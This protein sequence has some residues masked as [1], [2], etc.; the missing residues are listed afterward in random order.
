MALSAI[1]AFAPTTASAARTC[2]D[3]FR[4]EKFIS[5]SI[6]VSPEGRLDIRVTNSKSAMGQ[7]VNSLTRIIYRPLLLNRIEKVGERL[8]ADKRDNVPF[9]QK[10]SD[11]FGLEIRIDP[12]AL[13]NIPTSGPVI[14]VSNHPMNGVEGIALAAM[15]SK[16]RPDIK[17]VLTPLLGFVP[18]MAKN[19]IFANPYGGESARQANVQ[20]RQ[21]MVDELKAGHAFIIF[22][23]G[24]VSGK[25]GWLSKEV[26]DGQWKKGVAEMLN[27]VRDARVLP[28]FVEGTPSK[29]Y[30]NATLLADKVLKPFRSIR[31]GVG[32]VFHIREIGSRTETPVGLVIGQPIEGSEVLSWGNPARMMENLKRVT[33]NLRASRSEL[34]PLNGVELPGKKTRVLEPIAAQ[35]DMAVVHSELRN[36]ARIIYDRAPESSEKGMKVYLALGRDLPETMKEIGRL[37]EITFREVGEGS[38]KSRDLDSYDQDYYQLIAVD[39][40]TGAIA[41]GYRIAKVDEILKTRGYQGLYTSLFFDHSRLFRGNM[42]N[43]MELGR[44]FVVPE[45]QRSIAL[46]VLFA[47]IGRFVGENPKYRYL[48]GPVSITNELSERSKGIILEY[49]R[50]FYGSKDADLVIPLTPLREEFRISGEDHAFV[51]AQPTIAELSRKVQE[52]E[53]EMGTGAKMPTL[54]PIYSGL[55][56]KFFKF[57][58]D[59]EFNSIDGL[60]VVDFPMVETKNLQSYLGPEGVKPYRDFHGV[61]R[62]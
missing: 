20:A 35:T 26:E 41:G 7:F 12:A 53:N 47:G 32:A 3:L 46:A 36:K 13:A 19:A 17:V 54:V 29:A 58:F 9:W 30:L 44:S 22:P 45:Y 55:G 34:V 11:A 61:T 42:E 60:I 24:T 2:E 39:K 51:T 56:A 23:S 8:M 18:E 62:D 48:M 27:Q 21:Q 15:I 16:V 31:I 52:I 37:R 25:S 43:S 14:I 6:Q 57:N 38:G 49:L 4:K 50:Q 5:P 28:I 40:K 1:L 10:L 59:A 33:Y